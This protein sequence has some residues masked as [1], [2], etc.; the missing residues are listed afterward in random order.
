M[1]LVA[2]A[3]TESLYGEGSGRFEPLPR[4]D[5]ATPMS[6]VR[7]NAHQEG[8]IVIGNCAQTWEEVFYDMCHE[9]VHLLDPVVDVS[10]TEVSYLEEGCAVKFA[11]QMH[12]AYVRPYCDLVP[13]TS[14]IRDR[15]SP[16]HAAYAAA[17]KMPDDVLKQARRAFGTFAKVNDATRLGTIAGSFLSNADLELLASAFPYPSAFLTPSRP[18]SRSGWQ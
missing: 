16:Y 5:D 14:P 13:R 3:T 7:M 10:R 1:L 9:A 12:A 2:V 11:E 15:K 4:F 17:S 18:Q 6:Q 8:V